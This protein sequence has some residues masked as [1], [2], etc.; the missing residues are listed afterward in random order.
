MTEFFALSSL[1]RSFFALWALFL[2]LVNMGSTATAAVKRRWRTAALAFVLFVPVFFMWQIIF[3]LYLSEKSGTALF[4]SLAAGRLPWLLWLGVLALLTVASAVLLIYTLRY[5]KNYITPGAIKLFLDEIPC[6]ICCFVDNGKVLFSNVCMNELCLSLTGEPLLNGHQFRDAA[7]DEITSSGGRIW[8]FAYRKIV[9]EGETLHEIIA[10]DITAEYAKT[11]ALE[12][13]RAELSRLKAELA[14]YTLGIDD[15]VRRQ[16]ILQ[17]K[18]NIHDEMNRL[19]LSTVAAD[20][21][22]TAELDRIFSLWKQN[23]LLLCIEAGDSCAAGADVEKLAAALKIRLVWE[24][25]LPDG[26]SDGEKKL[27]TSA[28]K[29]AVV[30]A[31]KHAQA[32]ELIIS[33]EETDDGYVCRFTN[34]AE[35]RG[36]VRITGG[37]AN[38]SYLAGRSGASLSAESGDKFV[39]T[40]RF[41]KK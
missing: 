15:T 40:L 28:A 8:R 4:V 14:E 20:C 35:R 32:K 34:D 39:L 18:I 22:D 17:A 2:C 10:S 29:E 21:G 36:E 38:L 19:M 16:E 23:A 30:N 11:E 5:G 12:K 13:D 25:S 26:M 41:P 7:G 31:V 6:G 27:F 24:G 1:S 3:D 37:L 33:F 9:S